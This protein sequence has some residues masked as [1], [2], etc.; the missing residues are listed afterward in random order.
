MFGTQTGI[1]RVGGSAKGKLVIKPNTERTTTPAS[2][3]IQDGAGGEVLID[4]AKASTLGLLG[5]GA[6]ADSTA[7]DVAGIVTDFNALLAVLRTAGVIA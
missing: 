1:F 2:L 7:I 6:V 5:A 3:A 4:F